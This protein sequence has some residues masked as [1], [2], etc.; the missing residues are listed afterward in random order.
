MAGRVKSRRGSDSQAAV[1]GAEE[2]VVWHALE[3]LSV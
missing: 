1:S 2:K 3:A